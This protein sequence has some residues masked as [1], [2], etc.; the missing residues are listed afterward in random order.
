MSKSLGNSPDLLQLVED[1][2]ADTVRFG[3]M[4]SSPAGND[5]LFDEAQLEQGRNFCNKMWNALKLVKSWE[6][7]V[8]DNVSD[9]EVRFAIDWMEN[10]LAQ[11]A[12]EVAELM[13]DFRL[14]EG[15]KTI[16]SL[17]WNDFCSWYLEWVKP[18]FEQPMSQHVYERTVAIYEQLVQLLH[19]YMPFI[20]EEIY[21]QL[22]ER[23]AGDDLIIRILPAYDNID[24]AI[25]KQGAFLQELI[26]AIRD[27][28][29][30]NQLKP[31]DPI[32]LWI[33]TQ[34]HALYKQT[35]DILRRQ[36]NAEQIGFT[37]EAKQ[38]TISIVVQTDKLYIETA[39]ENINVDAQREQ[40][41][42]ELDYLKG[43]LQSV[44]KKL[45]NERFV[46]NAKPEVVDIEKK[47]KQDAEA[48]IKAIE[49]SLSLL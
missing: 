41:Q 31:K 8:A 11:V 49:E 14:S 29:N 16:Y 47:K 27:A 1:F 28:R 46:Q 7:R 33:D 5:L 45:S 4:I 48:K 37:E 3:V 10:R 9:A 35:Q 44:D 43:F 32:K 13:K 40:M 22:K 42:K 25:L 26:T 20:T 2:G 6:G 15:L 23:S 30:K 38:G 21:H 19:P 34:H 24:A 39:A 12:Q 17:I 18:G 36:V